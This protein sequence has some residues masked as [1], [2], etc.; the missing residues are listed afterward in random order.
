MLSDDAKISF[1]ML[2]AKK[3]STRAEAADRLLPDLIAAVEQF[4]TSRAK[5]AAE[6]LKV[7]DRQAEAGSRGTLLF[8]NWSNRFGMPGVSATST[9]NFE[10]PTDIGKPLTTPSGIRDPKAA[11]DM[12][13]AAAEAVEKQYGTLDKPWGEFLRLQ[14][15][16]QSAGAAAVPH[17]GEPVDGIDLP[18]NDGPGATYRHL[19]LLDLARTAHIPSL[20]LETMRS[21]AMRDC[22]R[23]DPVTAWHHF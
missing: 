13:D 23:H 7:W 5:K 11:A 12:L 6:V 3:L 16:I 19:P 15:N 2:L 17:S 18:G 14:I 1:D 22:R 20:S 4:G 8:W 21:W 10:T 9:R